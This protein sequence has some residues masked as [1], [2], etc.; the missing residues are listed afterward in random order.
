M[1]RAGASGDDSN[2]L[3]LLSTKEESGPPPEPSVDEDH[4]DDEAVDVQISS[5]T[6]LISVLE[7]WDAAPTQ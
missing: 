5:L 7:K 4:A 2:A 1:R 6:E 3:A